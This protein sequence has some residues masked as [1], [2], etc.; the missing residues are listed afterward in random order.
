MTEKFDCC[1]VG[2]GPAGLSAAMVMAEAGLKVL[3]I[4]RGEYPGSKNVMGGILYR[5]ATG[6]VFP[7]FWKEA[8]LER[9]IIG[10]NLWIADYH[11]VVSL[12]FRGE[13]HC[14][15]PYNAF[16]VLRAKFDRWMAGQ[17]MKAGGLIINE[18]V[19]EDFIREDGR[20]IGVKTG[21]PDGEV[22][23]DVVIVAEGVNSLLTQKLG[24]QRDLPATQLAVAVKEII[25]LPREKIE[26][27]FN[28]DE[29]EGV[30]I[31]IVG[32]ST[33]GMVGTGFIYTNRESLSV[34]V[35]TIIDQM[36]ERQINPNDLLESMKSHPV[37]RR[38]IQGGKTQEYLAHMIPEG[39]YKGIP[40]L[41]DDGVMIVGDAAM[42]VNGLHREGSNLAIM[43]GKL[44][45]ETVVQAK[46]FNDFS[47]KGL[48]EYIKRLTDSFVVKDLQKYQHAPQFFERNP[49]LFEKYPGMINRAALEF[50]TVDNMPKREKQRKI[51]SDLTEERS[52][53]NIARDLYGMWRVMG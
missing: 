38:L 9:H 23:A 28:L 22:Y 14:R 44:A 15:E 34:G 49:Q 21:R 11:S 29:N 1:V 27:R 32:F 41:V 10:Q 37:I 35:G 26:D 45:G 4:E 53:F 39:G 17:V 3:V 12:G 36:V 31:E 33:Q 18:T 42:L 13:Q 43:S 19:V 52:L 24:L 25:S 48:Y 30:T 2:A 20:V 7:D 5:K 6:E 51:I 8:P 50:L 16:S 46:E 40:K 47:A